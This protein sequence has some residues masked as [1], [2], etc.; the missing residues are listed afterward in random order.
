[1]ET[2]TATITDPT[3]K[4]STLVECDTRHQHPR[5]E[6]WGVGV[7]SMQFLPPG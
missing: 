7:I 6:I 3:S 1:M 5:S 4:T 2:V